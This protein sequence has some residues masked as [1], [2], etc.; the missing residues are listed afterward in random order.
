MSSTDLLS[1]KVSVLLILM[2][3]FDVPKFQCSKIKPT[4]L[5]IAIVLLFFNRLFLFFFFKKKK[6]N[7]NNQ[8]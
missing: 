7:E 5:K 8:N 6:N 2:N 3:N 1:I 4:N